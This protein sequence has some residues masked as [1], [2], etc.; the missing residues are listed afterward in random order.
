[1]SEPLK[2]GNG[3]LFVQLDGPNSDVHYLGCHELGDIEEPLGD[4]TLLWCPDPSAPNK[5]KKV[6]SYEGEPGTISSSI[7]TDVLKTADWLEALRCQ[8]T[9]FVNMI[10]CGR[11]DVFENWAR[12]FV[13]EGAR[14]STKRLSK[15]AVRKPG[16]QDESTQSFDIQAVALHRL[17]DVNVNRQTITE[18]QSLND[19]VFCN[20]PRCQDE[21]G[22][23]L[24][25]CQTGFIVSDFLGASYSNIANVLSTV[26]G[27][28][29][30]WL[31]TT[32]EPFGAAMDIA[33]VICVEIGG[34]ITRTIVARG[35]QD[36]GPMDIAYSDDG[37]ATAWVPVAVG[38]VDD[39][40][41]TMGGTLFALDLYHIWLVTTGGYVY[42]SD[43]AGVTWTAQSAGVPSAKD[44][45]HIDFAD[46]NYGVAVGADEQMLYTDDGG[47]TWQLILGAHPG[48]DVDILCV[49]VRDQYRWW[50]GYVDGSLWYT[51]DGGTTFVRRDYPEAATHTAGVTDI[52]FVN[53]L[54]GYMIANKTGPVLGDVYR[55]IN[56]GR[57]WR[58]LTDTP[59]NLGL[60]E[61]WSCNVN[62]AYIVGE[63]EDGTGVVLKVA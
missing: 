10:E 61:I 28:A 34:G 4:L 55:T 40:Y 50:I 19:V 5:F 43:D 29:D 41:A 36:G 30:G 49:D 53:D 27:G 23:A 2:G 16:D 47:A 63:A 17:L 54:V 32:E 24:D 14:V 46:E 18:E 57:S 44:L 11:K 45:N 33:S 56:G 1:M 59:L 58:Q 52:T 7:L 25:Y 21:C 6:G 9:L 20:D 13:L 31:E 15:L 12:S 39:Q 51:E 8:A 37:G 42:F 26:D 60:N 22:V 62:M 3:A 48:D 38:A 35:T